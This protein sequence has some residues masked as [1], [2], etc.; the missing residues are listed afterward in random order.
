MVAPRP[1]W[2]IDSAPIALQNVQTPGA[3]WQSAKQQTGLSALRR[4]RS[5]PRWCSGKKAAAPERR[6]SSRPEQAG[7]FRRACSTHSCLDWLAAAAA[8]ILAGPVFR[9]EPL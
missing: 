9:P 1:D 6:F 3:D 5:R 2:V 7:A 4:T 8:A